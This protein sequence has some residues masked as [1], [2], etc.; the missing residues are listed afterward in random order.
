[1]SFVL[2]M[3]GIINVLEQGTLINLTAPVTDIRNLKTI[4]THLLNEVRAVFRAVRTQLTVLNGWTM[5]LTP[6]T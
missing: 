6:A 4:G 3:L 1:M 5:T 2:R